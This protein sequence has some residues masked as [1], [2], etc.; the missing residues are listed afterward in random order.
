MY[1]KKLKIQDIRFNTY[2]YLKYVNYLYT[3]IMT[4]GYAYIV[5][6]VPLYES[7]FELLK[8]TQHILKD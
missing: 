1:I 8:K 7:G 6:D 2:T 3:Y 4:D 5:S